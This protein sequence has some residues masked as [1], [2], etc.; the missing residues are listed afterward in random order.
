MIV[1]EYFQVRVALGGVALLLAVEVVVA[2]ATFVRLRRVNEIS[3]LELFAQA[4][5][6]IAL[7][8]AMLYITG[9]TE[10]PFAPLFVLPMVIVA[11]ALS[12][13]WVWVMAACTM[14]AYV[15]LRVYRLEINHP[16]GHTHVYKLHEDGMVINYLITAALLAFFCN[17]MH[18]AIRR[19]ER[20]LADARDVQMR[21]ES[22]VAIGALAAG[23]AHELSSP[24]ATVAVAAAELKRHCP[25]GSPMQHDLELIAD[26]VAQCKRI[27]SSLAS[28]G[29]ERRAESASAVRVDRFLEMAVERAR[30]LNPG[31]SITATFDGPTPPPMIVG[32]ETLRLA[33]MNLVQ[34]AAQASPDS[35]QVTA[36]WSAEELCVD[37]RDRGPGFPAAILDRLGRG[38]ESTK[39]ADGNGIGLLLSVATLER[40]GGRLDVGNPREGGAR[41]SI[42]VPMRGIA[43]EGDRQSPHGDA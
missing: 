39:G 23:Y 28:A 14:A 20:L 1:T 30:A 33:I 24:L 6:D 32:E 22:V 40:L 15:A 12:P 8:A 31:A 43:I 37:V 35:V 41:A 21:N 16:E 3:P 25:P 26:Q 18:G 36:T 17:R 38:I 42:R 5:L 4:L 10:N 2:G 29:G 13:R 27:V 19:N 7:Y 34:N 9:G 11:S